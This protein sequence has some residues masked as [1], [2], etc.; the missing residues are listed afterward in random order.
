M[1]QEKSKVD[2]LSQKLYSRTRYQAPLDKR[3]PVNELEVPPGTPEVGEKW[4]SPELDELLSHEMEG[5]K[6]TPFM[7]KFFI[8]SIF[9]FIATIL[10]AGLVFFGGVNFISS[11]NVDINIVGPTTASAG[12]I[13][14]LGVTIENGNNTDLELANFSVQYPAG[15]RDPQDTS[16]TLTYTKESL[17]VIKAGD[18]AVRNVRL[19]LLGSLGDVLEIKLSVEYKV[20]GS[21][22]TFYKDKVYQVTVGDS[23]MTLSVKT[24]ESVSS[25]DTFTTEI[26]V[27]LNATEVLKN[28]M[29]RGEYPYGYSVVSATPAALSENN[30]WALGDLSPGVEK[31]I[32]IRG[33]LVGENQ[34]ER[35]FRFYVGVAEGGSLSPNFK[36]IVLSA[37]ETIAIER[38]AI[39]LTVNF[40]GETTPIYIAPAGQ[41]VSTNLK[42]QNNLPEKLLNPKLEVRLSGNAL[43]RS[44]ISVQ[45]NGSLNNNNARINWNLV[46]SRQASELAPGEG[47]T[48]SFSFASLPEFNNG[49][50]TGEVALEFILTGTPVGGSANVTVNEAR[51]VRIASQV[52]LAS[53]VTHSIGPF[54][55]T[56]PI[57]PKAGEET[58]YGVVWSL[59]NT[60]SDLDEARVTAKLGPN[61][62]WVRATSI[63][64]EEIR[65]DEETNTITWNLN[66]LSSGAGFS[67]P[68]RE[69][70]FQVALTPSAAQVGTTP[71]LV[72][73]IA[74]TGRNRESGK[75]V[76]IT[77]QPLT[78]KL[79]SDPAFIQGDD[80]VV[81]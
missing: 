76:T 22:A 11:K 31:R 54:S 48:V 81:K 61:V 29:L 43:N 33:R 71:N 49:N 44:S 57:P 20:K 8:F 4:Q 41:L 78:T 65:Y 47:G 12:E 35:T 59:G 30:V 52:T 42:Y 32:T 62:K 28:V 36:T 1:A 53:R 23:P 15:S 51:T 14:E 79:P 16:K 25:G 38:P 56:G 74:F 18:E 55:N 80:I 58:T 45:N 50:N 63:Q 75:I 67:T 5:V 72:T 73:S 46:N 40:N 68:T 37:Q 3:S 60:Q 77:N 9:F 17:G 7:K 39:G 70:A 64:S 24:P 69:V 21:N 34:D 6:V 10:V 27:V 66:S 13:L 19:L 26:S 2:Q